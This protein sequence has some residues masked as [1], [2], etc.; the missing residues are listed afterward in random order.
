MAPSDGASFS[1]PGRGA[2]AE[3]LTFE[4][5]RGDGGATL[6]VRSDDPAVLDSFTGTAA[7][8]DVLACPLTAENAKA[9]AAHVPSLRPEASGARPSFGFGDRLG[10][11]TDGHIDALA[12]AAPD[13]H[14]VLAQQSVRELTRAGRTA[15]QVVA[16]AVWGAVAT[17]W[18]GG[19]GADADHLQRA[20]DI[21]PFVAAGYRMFTLDPHLSVDEE[22]DGLD[23]SALATRFAALPWDD[24]GDA[25]EDL[26][27]RYAEPVELETQAVGVSAE[28]LTR[29]AVKYGRALVHVVG[30]NEALRGHLAGAAFDVEVS[31]DESDSPTSLAEHIYLARELQRLGVTVTSLAPRFP[32]AF[33]KGVD[34]VGDLG[35]LRTALDAHAEIARVSGDYKLSLHSGSDKFSIY[36]LFAEATRGH[37]H[38]KTSGTSYLEG[39]RVA[40]VFEPALFKAIWALALE[41]YP[42][43]RQTYHV[44]AELRDVPAVVADGALAALLDDRSARQILHVTF[45]SVLQAE[46][47]K[48]AL[49]ATL[50]ARHADY[51]EFL[52]RH[53]E[54][55][56]RP[57]VA[58]GARA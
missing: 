16:D 55:H 31:V 53:F 22:A 18:T 54:A 3:G 26:R 23:E 40:A 5:R 52:Q 58:V 38:V 10:G 33:E 49:L 14:P 30:L 12:A 11:A 2:A 29:A 13:V 8:D 34:Y 1:T 45:G 36:P 6:L 50:R 48:T 44:S 24:L 7:G 20:E 27:A 47:L 25:P 28:D 15:D 37:F 39:L 32:G 42:T 21:E 4:L 19:F 46:G 56:L 9:L 43:D 35:A 57:L 51:T 41:R 17:G